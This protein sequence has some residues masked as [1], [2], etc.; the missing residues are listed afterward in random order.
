MIAVEDWRIARDVVHHALSNGLHCAVASCNPDGKPHITPIGSVLLDDEPGTGIYF[1][2]FNTRLRRNVEVNREVSILA[3]DSRKDLWL[4]ALTGGV[5][6]TPPAVQLDATVGARRAATPDETARFERYI[7]PAMS[8][9]GGRAMWG[10]L[11]HV[12]EFTVH[13]VDT[14]KI[15]SLTRPMD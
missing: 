15:G 2:V 8:T 3:V 10:N 5:F 14:V 7:R 1:D 6:T 4:D 11:A 12:R 9:P 13:A